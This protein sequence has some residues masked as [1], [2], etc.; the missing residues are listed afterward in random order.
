MP[1]A[2]KRVCSEPGCNALVDYGRCPLHARP[3]EDHRPSRHK[4][5]YDSVHER[6]RMMVLARHP[7]CRMCGVK[8]SVV[9]DHIEPLKW[10]GD[11][12]LENGQGLC[13]ACHNRKTADERMQAKH[14]RTKTNRN[15]NLEA[16]RF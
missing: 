13:K 2:P 8:P 9:A 10:G 6:W 5:G 16:P 11:W 4:R 12:R 3:R 1:R 15:T 14:A 7:I